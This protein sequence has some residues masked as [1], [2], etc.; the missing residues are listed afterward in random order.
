VSALVDVDRLGDSGQPPRIV[1]QPSLLSLTA[2]SLVGLA[3][4]LRHLVAPSLPRSIGGT[5]CPTIG[6]P[7]CTFFASALA[8][9]RGIELRPVEL[10]SDGAL[11]GFTSYL[12]TA[13]IGLADAGS[14]LVSSAH[15]T[16]RLAPEWGHPGLDRSAIARPSVG[17]PWWNDVAFAGY[18]ELVADRRFLIAGD[19][20]T[21]RWLDAE[22]VPTADGLEFFQRAAD[23][24]WADISL[25]AEGREGRSW[26][27]SDNPHSYQPDHAFADAETAATLRSF[28]IVPWPVRALGLSDHAPLLFDLHLDVI[29]A[30]VAREAV[31][32]TSDA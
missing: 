26:Y 16:A 15:T 7:S 19:W 3:V 13:E 18:R 14:L 28:A 32:V 11:D 10:P 23:A 9:R 30:P 27:G 22:G 29:E 20:N 31:L 17:E 24:G 4:R 6:L 8:A 25:D 1:D 5:Y 21:A 2:P 12:A